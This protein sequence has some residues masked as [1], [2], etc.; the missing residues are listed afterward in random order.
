MVQVVLRKSN[1]TWNCSMSCSVLWLFFPPLFISLELLVLH[2]VEHS[3]VHLGFGH[4]AKT[5]C[6][7][8]QAKW[9]HKFAGNSCFT[10]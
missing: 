1:S 6:C 10:C 5:C 9:L 7:H 2:T 3:W 4:V 8:F